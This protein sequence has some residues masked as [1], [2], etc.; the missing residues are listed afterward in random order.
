MQGQTDIRKNQKLD[1]KSG[2]LCTLPLRIRRNL[3][4]EVLRISPGR[5]GPTLLI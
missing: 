5:C 2:D 1:L 4:R 3:L